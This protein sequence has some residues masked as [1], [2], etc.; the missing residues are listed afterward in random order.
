MK[1]YTSVGPNPHTVRMFMAERNIALDTETIDIIAGDN[2]KPDYLAINPGGQLPA[3]VRM[4][5]RC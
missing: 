1:L 3:L 4:M 5:A 2:R